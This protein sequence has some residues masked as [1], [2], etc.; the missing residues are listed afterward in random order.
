[1]MKQHKELRQQTLKELEST[2]TENYQ[3]P[4][5]DIINK[6]RLKERFR[7]SWWKIKYALNP[8]QKHKLLHLMCQI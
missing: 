2:R 8:T 3:Q 4:M 6:T 5:V 1:M 7:N